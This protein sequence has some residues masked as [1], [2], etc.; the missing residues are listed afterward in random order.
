MRDGI[1]VGGR[2]LPMMSEIARVRFSQFQDD[3]VRALYDFLSARARDP[4]THE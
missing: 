2:E 1:A 4:R 3:E